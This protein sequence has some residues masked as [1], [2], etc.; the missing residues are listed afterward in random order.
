[1][2]IPQV[3]LAQTS[4]QSI[5][6]VTLLTP[7]S[8]PGTIPAPG[9]GL[10]DQ[11]WGAATNSTEDSEIPT[12]LNKLWKISM[13]GSMYRTLCF[14]GVLIA[15]FAVGFWCVKLYN[16]LQEGGLRPVAQEML[17]PIL[18]VIMLSNNGRNFKDLTLATRDAMNG[19]NVTL[20]RVIQNSNQ[21]AINVAQ[22]RL[23]ALQNS[24]LQSIK[25]QLVVTNQ[26]NASTARI[27]QGE[28]QKEI[29]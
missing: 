22:L 24:D 16:T 27:S 21:S 8:S 1:M 28:F 26:A 7:D 23:L 19:F 10:L 11:L 2:F 15:V 18:L 6:G 20:N 9:A 5:P 29:L 17:Y 13:E 14:L 4:E 25:T 12:A 3:L